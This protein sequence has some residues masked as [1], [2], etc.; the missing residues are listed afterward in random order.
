MAES[1]TSSRLIAL[2]LA[3][4][5]STMDNEEIESILYI[6]REVSGHS[7]FSHTATCWDLLLTTQFG[8]M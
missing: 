6:A 2:H 4:P 7:S 1:R 3:S 5:P 8:I